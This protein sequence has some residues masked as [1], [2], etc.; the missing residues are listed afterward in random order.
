MNLLARIL[1]HGF[2]LAVVALIAIALMNRGDLFPE[3][4]LPD[5]LVIEDKSDTGTDAPAGSLEP[6]PSESVAVSPDA[7][8]M[9]PADTPAEAVAEDVVTPAEVTPAEVTPEEVIPAEVIPAEV[10]PEEVTPEEVSPAEVI[11]AE[12]T[13]EE[14]TLE[15]VTPAEAPVSDDVTDSAPVVDPDTDAGDVDAV[16]EASPEESAPESVNSRPEAAGA[17]SSD[18]PESSP[19]E[20]EAS[21]GQAEE[22]V[23]Q[24][25][26]TE[27]PGQDGQDGGAQDDTSSVT[28][29]ATVI[30]NEQLEMPAPE[31]EVSQPAAEQ[32]VD[33]VPAALASEMPPAAVPVDTGKST[34]ELLATA[35]EAYWLHDYE[36]AETYYQQL[37]QADPDNPDGYGELGNMHFAQGQWEPAATAY[38]EAGVRLL[39]TGMLVQARQL[40]EVIRG[41]NGT[42]ADDLERQIEAVN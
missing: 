17:V 34:Y 28:S 36:R 19:E 18:A 11:P 38:Y 21:D 1:S 7:G 39:N 32:V 24:T 4:K 2:A 12:V 3:W 13:P 20:T 42:Q 9:A 30:V 37:I 10:I 5:F 33:L 16:Q 6:A 35:R 25:D 31:V 29:A 22:A 26:Q 27:Q 14:V 8:V 23:D 15:E 40:V 41:L